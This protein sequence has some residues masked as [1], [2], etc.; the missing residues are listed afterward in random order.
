MPTLSKH[1][2]NR[3]GIRNSTD[4]SPFGVELDGRTV[5]L[6]GYR[7][8]FNT[9][10]KT[11]EISGSGNHTTALYWEYDS[12]L[13]RR[14]NLDPKPNPSISSF[15][16]FSNNSVRNSDF[17]GDTIRFAE[18]VNAQQQSNYLAKLE[19]LKSSEL[20]NYYYS[21]LEKSNTIFYINCNQEMLKGGEYNPN[22]N[23]ISYKETSSPATIAQELFHAYQ[24]DLNVY[25]SREDHAV[26]EAEGDIMTQY[27]VNEANLTSQGIIY[28]MTISWG[29][30]ILNISNDIFINPTNQ[31]VQSSNYDELFNKASKA[32]VEYYKAKFNNGELNYKGYTS[33]SSNQKPLAIKRVF[34]EIEQH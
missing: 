30:E 33:E 24:F 7:F 9:Q 20:F 34:N 6:D 21:E 3:V 11:D 32:R 29:Q 19:I 14:W 22:N 12:R 13:G 25:D 15:S 26:M 17:E 2:P 10:E 23:T 28:E 16:T 18:S 27:V 5:S 1:S 31:Q 4:Y 8:G